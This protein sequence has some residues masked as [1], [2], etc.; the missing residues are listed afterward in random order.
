MEEI[1]TSATEEEDYKEFKKARREEEARAN[2][3]K[4]EC[5]L[6]SPFTDRATLKERCK[7]AD[8]IGLGAVVVFPSVVKSCASF[9]GKDPKTALIAAIDYPFGEETTETKVAAVK[10]AV[11][12]GVDEVEVCAPFTFIRE[13][14]LSYFKKECKKIRKAASRRAV[15]VV[16]D[17]TALTEKELLKAVQVA[18]DAK[19]NCVRLNGGDGETV[20]NVKAALKGRCMIKAERAETLSAFS[21]L[22]AMGADAVSCKNAFSLASLMIKAASD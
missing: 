2:V 15:R 4:M 21:N 13:G 6:L 11:R 20:A 19:I 8:S 18:A 9:L 1:K 12:D 10:Q 17:C 16:F 7:E 3:L 22:C 14:N 5:D